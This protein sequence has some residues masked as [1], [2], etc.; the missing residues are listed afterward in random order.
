M[1]SKKSVPDNELKENLCKIVIKVGVKI[2]DRA[3]EPCHSVIV[4]VV[5]AVQK[6]TLFRWAN[7]GLLKD[8]GGGKN[9]PSLKSVS[10]IFQSWNLAQLYL[11]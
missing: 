7:L 6:L 9:T 10:H 1:N 2:N 11:T 5:K 3:T 4:L 8:G